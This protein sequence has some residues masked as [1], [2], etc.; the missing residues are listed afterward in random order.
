MKFRKSWAAFRLLP[1]LLIC[2]LPLSAAHAAPPAQPECEPFST[3]GRILAALPERALEPVAIPAPAFASAPAANAVQTTAAPTG[4]P[5]QTVPATTLAAL[6]Q[7]TP[8]PGDPFPLQPT[9]APADAAVQTTPA[10]VAT[11]APTPFT[12]VWFPDT[13]AS[14]YAEPEALVAMGR[15]V[16]EHIESDNIVYVLQTGDLVDNGFVERQ[17]EN[18]ELAYDQFAGK[19]PYFC[20]AGNHDRGVKRQE[21][22][23]YLA[24]PYAHTVPPEQELDGGKSAYTLFSAGGIDFLVVGVG[25]GAELASIAWARNTFKRYPDRYGILMMH[26]YLHGTGTFVEDN[27]WLMYY[28]VVAHCP[29]LYMTLSGH[30]RGTCYKTFPF[31]D[32]YDEKPDRIV[33]SFLCNYQNYTRLGG[34]LRLLR[35]DPADGSLTV[36]T[37]SALTGSKMRDSTMKQSTFTLKHVFGPTMARP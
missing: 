17:W 26:A 33:H 8:P 12:I 11:P 4:N 35:F 10:P 5:L 14:A 13:Q 30:Y 15:W 31:D 27:P 6:P 28:R 37:F 25:D 3:V 29:N 32:T 36:E 21:W 2:L 19:V 9:P 18:F 7:P 20:I 23:G 24:R 34:Q 1:T 16:S 22:D